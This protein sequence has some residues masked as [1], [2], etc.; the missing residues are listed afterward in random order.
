[1]LQ[2]L[3]AAIQTGSLTESVTSSVQDVAKLLN[4]RCKTQQPNTGTITKR[5]TT[6]QHTRTQ[7]TLDFRLP[8]IITKTTETCKREFKGNIW[9]FS[10]ER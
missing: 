2:V 4:D 8:Y 10:H 9:H 3:D 5:I 7:V 6:L 1:M